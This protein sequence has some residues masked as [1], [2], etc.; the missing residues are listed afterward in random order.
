[1]NVMIASPL[2]PQ[3]VARI[4]REA[5][6]D[7]VLYDSALLPAPRYPNDHRGA[8]LTL[9]ATQQA[10]WDAMLA[11]AEALFGYPQEAGTGLAHSL[12]HGPR[13][14]FVQGTSAGMGAHIRRANLPPV[15]LQRVAFAS[16]AGVHAQMLAE[17]AFFGMLS[18]RKDAVRLARL[19]AERRWEHYAM[20]ELADQTLAVVGFGQIGRAVA[21]LA[22]AFAMRVVAAARSCPE[23]PS[24]D[25]FFPM[26]RVRDAFALAD[27]VV[28]ALPATAQTERLIDA[29]TLAALRENC[30]FVN[31]GR[32]SVID[33]KALTELL[34]G[35]RI[36]GAVLD[37]FDPE[38]LPADDPLWTLPNVVLSPHTAGLSIHEN[39]RITDLFCDNLHRLH[40][41]RP[42]R[43]RVDL[44]EF[45]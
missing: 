34:Q 41:G 12:A 22:R 1:M 8:D 18:L 15:A 11:R 20:G 26:D 5:L 23:H 35:G 36:G 39:E 33:Q 14:R 43:N 24:I 9:D 37:V 16:A 2:E 32:G 10:R 45:Y 44:D 40:D 19:R 30:I 38:P 7:E 25:R 31:V 27:A 6:V 3:L 21:Q 13:V 42:L 4:S 28:V 17:F 29:R